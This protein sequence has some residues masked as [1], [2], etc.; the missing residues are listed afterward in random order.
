MISISH[1]ASA[2]KIP[3]TL[4]T[5]LTFAVSAMVALLLSFA[6][7]AHGSFSRTKR[8]LVPG[9]ER[10]EHPRTA[11]FGCLDEG[12]L[13]SV[14][15]RGGRHYDGDRLNFLVAI[16][17]DAEADGLE[18][19][20]VVITYK[21]AGATVTYSVSIETLRDHGDLVMGVSGKEL[22]LPI[23]MWSI[24]GAPPAATAQPV[25]AAVVVEQPTL[26]DYAEPAGGY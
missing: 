8:Y 7:G 9:T 26:F 25:K 18:T 4:S 16:L 22:S 24:N 15:T 6:A 13:R 10:D 5:V 23:R 12:I 20:E 3:R 17:D 2:V 1:A 14:R 11:A 21:R 19:A